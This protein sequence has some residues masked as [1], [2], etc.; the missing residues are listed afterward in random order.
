MDILLQITAFLITVLVLV[1]I[2]EAGHFWVARMLN[3]KVLCFSIGFGKPIWRRVA[4]NGIEYI[5]GV[6]PLGGYVKLLD[7]R[8]GE[9]TDADKP[10]AFNRQTLWKR[11]LVVAAGPVTNI[12]FAIFAFWLMYAIGFETM[13]PIV[14]KI[15]P[16]SP[17]AIAGLPAN[18]EITAIDGKSIKNWQDIAL[19]VIKRMGGE[20]DMT[21][22]T[23][24]NK[25]YVVDV[26]KWRVNDLN[27]EPLRSLGLL[28][29]S[30]PVKPLLEMV[31]ENSAAEKAGFKAGDTILAVD[32]KAIENWSELAYFLQKHPDASV[33][34]TIDREGKQLQI[35]VTIGSRFVLSG[36]RHVGRLGVKVKTPE[37]PDEMKMQMKYSLGG[38][39]VKGSQ[40][41]FGFFTFNFIVLKKMV[42]GEISLR[43]LG[44]PITIF[45]TADRAFKQGFISFLSFLALISVMLA[46][47]NVIPVPGLDGG[48]LL[49]FL[50]EFII[51][52]PLSLAMEVL[53]MRLGMVALLL[54]ML[55]A[56][57]NDI[58]RLLG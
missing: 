31:E 12:V 19:T 5:V 45:K 14:G 9:V 40:E 24:K 33:N 47:V 50:I 26:G 2:H 8:E 39:F 17:V 44:G 55:A 52:R 57:M 27:P 54:L 20:G 23:K 53:T 10:F 30:P 25:S 6:L 35:P 15:L 16:D 34:I 29:F 36:W 4:K 7:E 3:I 43:S 32:N 49:Y 37:M 46:F 11:F 38:A 28:P 13:R 42:A 41:T 18:A 56:T 51:R 1:S 22:T 48:H 58:L 21:I